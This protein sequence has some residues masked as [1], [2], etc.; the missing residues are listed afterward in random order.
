M[1][2]SILLISFCTIF[3]SCNTSFE[4]KLIDDVQP[5]DTMSDISEGTNATINKINAVTKS[6]SWLLDF[7]SN[8]KIQLL[9]PIHNLVVIDSINSYYTV[10]ENNKEL[11]ILKKDLIINMSSRV[12]LKKLELYSKP[13]ITQLLD[14]QVTAGTILFISSTQLN[15][16]YL[17]KNLAD[18]KT[19]F[20]RKTDDFL[21]SQPEDID[22]AYRI[23]SI[24]NSDQPEY[25]KDKMIEELRNE[26]GFNHNDWIQPANNSTEDFDEQEEFL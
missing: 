10:L 11:I 21:S 13:E 1:K 6:E 22:Y 9:K 26:E 24:I 12:A 18:D 2:S 8:R 23:N 5:V 25:V 16:F 7:S 20:I 17:I 14:N 15:D 4:T 3:I 19:Y